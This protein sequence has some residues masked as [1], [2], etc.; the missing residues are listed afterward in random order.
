MNRLFEWEID[1][2][3]KLTTFCGVLLV[4][5]HHRVQFSCYLPPNVVTRN[6]LKFDVLPCW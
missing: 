4:T 2:S 3:V 5:W 1:G 6:V